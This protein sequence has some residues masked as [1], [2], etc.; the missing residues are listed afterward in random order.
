[1]WGSRGSCA[2]SRAQGDLI[3]LVAHH[4]EAAFA[5]VVSV[6]QPC[7]F[8]AHTSVGLELPTYGPRPAAHVLGAAGSWL[9]RFLLRRCAAV[10]AVSPRLAKRLGEAA[11]RE[12]AYLPIPWLCPAP[13]QPAERLAARRELRL[14]APAVLYSGNLDA[15]QGV[16]EMITAFAKVRRSV[17]LNRAH[18]GKP[19]A[20]TTHRPE[21]RCRSKAAYSCNER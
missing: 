16:D 7:F 4:V 20:H 10:A 13:I 17:T 8:L 6:G 3:G 19:R 1:M 15:Y 11:G 5:T 9:D 2:V 14:D 12:V 21:T 18:R